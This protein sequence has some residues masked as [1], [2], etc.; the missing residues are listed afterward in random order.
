VTLHYV[1]CALCLPFLLAPTLA[2]KSPQTPLTAIVMPDGRYSSVAIR[3][4][5]REAASILKNSGV[6]L[7][8]RLEASP[9]V[10]DGLLVVV[11]LRGQC[12]MDGTAPELQRG[13]LGWSHE[14]NGSLL[15][16]SELACDNIRGAVQSTL[17][18]DN[19]MRGNIL[20]GRAMGRVLAHELYHI[21]AG[22]AKHGQNGAAQPALS[23]RELTTGQLEFQRSDVEAIQNGLRQPR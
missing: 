19:Q 22:T 17:R 9:E 6:A 14:V 21:V 3:E 13:P 23:A 18:A 15:P 8:W 12:E 2:G 5:G 4:M 11:M 7:R 1:R 16:F 10:S 20:L